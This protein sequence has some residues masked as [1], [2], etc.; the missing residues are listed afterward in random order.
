MVIT[1]MKHKSLRTLI[2][3]AMIA[4]AP[5]FASI[6][7]VGD[8]N[9]I[10]DMTNP[11]DGLRYLDMTF[12]DG[13]TLADALANAQA[14]YA[15]ARLAT[16]SEWDDLFMAAG[17]TYSGAETASDAFLNGATLT[18]TPD[19]CALCASL[20]DKL[21]ATNGLSG[22]T[23]WLWSD[24]DGS[25]SAAGTRDALRLFDNGMSSLSAVVQIDTTVTPSL[26]P[27]SS[28]FGYLLVSE[29]VVPLPPAIIFL[30]SGIAALILRRRAN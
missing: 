29:A 27:G 30:G 10:N 8:L 25:G 13:L 4:A 28:A 1:R 5:A 3:V 20:R 7:E 2:I 21:G 26:M 17:I 19:P 24:P 11:S 22:D 14:T 15:D 6:D 18:I 23:T 16:P 9:I 12:S